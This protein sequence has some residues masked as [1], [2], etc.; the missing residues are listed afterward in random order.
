MYKYSLIDLKDLNNFI[1]NDINDF[2]YNRFPLRLILIEDFDVWKESITI[3]KHYV[4][5]VIKISDYVKNSDGYPDI[6]EIILD[7][8]D[9]VKKGNKVLCIPVEKVIEISNDINFLRD[10]A[11]F[12]IDPKKNG[13]IYILLKPNIHIERFLN[14]QQ[15]IGIR[16]AL[17]IRIKSKRTFTD[18]FLSFYIFKNERFLKLLENFKDLEIIYGFRDYLR[19]WE[20]FNLERKDKILVYSEIIY[21]SIEESKGYISVHKIANIKELLEKF[22]SFSIFISYREEEKEFWENLLIDLIETKE[23]DFKNYLCKKFNIRKI[24]KVLFYNWSYFNS[25]EK[26]LL[27][28]WAKRELSEDRSYLFKVLEKSKDLKDFEELIWNLLL[29]E[30]EIT[31]KDLEERKEIIKKSKIEPPISFYQLLDEIDPF[32]KLQLLPGLND[33]EKKEIIKTLSLCIKKGIKEEDL[34]RILELNYPELAY[35]LAFPLENFKFYFEKYIKAK[36]LNSDFELE[37]L[38]KHAK[39]FD[40]YS[41]PP[42][43]SL[44]EKFSCPQIWIDGLGIEW[45]GLIYRWLSQQGYYV[46][47]EIARANLPTTTEF[48]NFPEGVERFAD[49]DEIYHRQDRDYPEYLVEEIEKIVRLLK[50]KIKPLVNK[51]GEIVITSDHG[52]TRYAGWMEEKIDMENIEIFYNGRFAKWLSKKDPEYHEDY[53]IERYG[54]WYYLISKTHKNFKNGKKTKVE[55]HGG[56]TPEEA[57]V[58][59]IHIKF[60]PTIEMIKLK[61]T[62]KE[63]NLLRPQIEIETNQE[64]ENLKIVILET[65]IEGKKISKIKWTFDLGSVKSKLKPD[66]YKLKIVS[67][68]GEKEEEIIIKGGLEEESLFEED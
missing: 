14:N 46:N 33:Y 43:N 6:Y 36:I 25:Y 54:D 13:R 20:D 47:I 51:Y 22:F 19:F 32:I 62:N 30:K 39:E 58:P 55:N 3:I 8:K 37:T 53:Y 64:V 63:I 40:L 50:E 45:V 65:L 17:P 5:R 68:I 52:A 26:W 4:D 35:Y 31:I 38:Y 48:N 15:D 42:R 2:S 34:I 61:V 21:N 23:K 56:G 67:D 10:L 9:T 1:K 59:V 24:E 16:K 49:L 18:S 41:Y 60:K 11:F 27:Y 29:D 7:I 66:K 28:N 12:E 57:L 44:L